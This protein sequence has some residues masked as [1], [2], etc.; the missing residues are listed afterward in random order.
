LQLSQNQSRRI[1]LDA[2]TKLAQK[3]HADQASDA[4]LVGKIEEYYGEILHNNTVQIVLE[5][6]Q[7]APSTTPIP[8]GTGSPV[9]KK[10]SSNFGFCLWIS[11][12]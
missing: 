12:P 8:S 2:H 4:Q 5:Y 7:V 6:G 9:K 3:I 1:G 10:N 11:K